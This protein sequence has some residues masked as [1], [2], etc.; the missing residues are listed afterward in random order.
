[1]QKEWIAGRLGSRLPAWGHRRYVRHGDRE[2]IHGVLA[3]RAAGVAPSTRPS[4]AG[5]CPARRAETALFPFAIDKALLRAAPKPNSASGGTGLRTGAACLEPGQER[6]D[7]GDGCRRGQ[8]LRGYAAEE[9]VVM[10]A[11]TRD[12]TI[13]FQPLMTS[14]R[15]YPSSG[16]RMRSARES[17]AMTPQRSPHATL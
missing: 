3:Q 10:H 6:S 11:L 17:A 8:G 7:R 1:M 14:E 5:T 12:G 15:P 16:S 4:A 2:G 9:W 13:C